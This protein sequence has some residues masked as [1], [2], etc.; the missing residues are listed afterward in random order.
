MDGIRDY[1][2]SV[3][4]AALFCSVVG[5][6]T[7]GKSATSNIIKLLSGIFLVTVILKPVIA[8][9]LTDWKHFEVDL[10]EKSSEAVEEGERLALEALSES[11]AIS[12]Q[13][14]VKQEAGKL[15]CQLEVTVFWEGSAPKEITL[16][17]DVSPYTKSVMAQWITDNM[18]IPREAQL[19]I[20]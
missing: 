4:C 10:M 11:A 8:V 3:C 15:G 1:L 7:G 16:A 5:I 13:S 9:K 17:G 18:G 12:A 2:L 20:G 14:L 6:L 19:W